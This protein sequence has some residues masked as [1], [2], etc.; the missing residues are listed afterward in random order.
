[1]SLLSL[2]C[3]VRGTGAWSP[4]HQGPLA[5][6]FLLGTWVRVVYGLS[7]SVVRRSDL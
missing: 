7:Y 2:L 1:M 3:E 6:R 4:Q 5:G